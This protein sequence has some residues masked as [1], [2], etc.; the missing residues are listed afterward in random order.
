MSELSQEIKNEKIRRLIRM[1][2]ISNKLCIFLFGFPAQEISDGDF[3]TKQESWTAAHKIPHRD[4][5]AFS[6]SFKRFVETNRD[7]IIN[8]IPLEDM[9]QRLSVSRKWLTEYFRDYLRTDYRLWRNGIKVE[10]AKRLLV[11]EPLASVSDIS[12]R[13]GVA[14]ISN[15]YKIFRRIESCTPSEWRKA[16]LEKITA[17]GLDAAGPAPL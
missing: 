17:D 5:S 9:A 16:A 3:A 7:E 12:S 1:L 8:N 6:D 2:G 15:F 10:Y 11:E 13:C 4:F 14:D